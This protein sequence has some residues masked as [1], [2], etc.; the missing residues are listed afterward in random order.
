M[1]LGN[2]ETHKKK[3]NYKK[4]KSATYFLL[5]FTILIEK[6]KKNTINLPSLGEALPIL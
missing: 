4:K 5:P 6:K 3:L 2:S 1:D